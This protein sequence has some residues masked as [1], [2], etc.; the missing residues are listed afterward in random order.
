MARKNRRL[1][2]YLANGPGPPIENVAED[3]SFSIALHIAYNYLLRPSSQACRGIT[4]PIKMTELKELIR[5]YCGLL[6]QETRIEERKAHLKAAIAEQ[7]AQTNLTSTTTEHGSAVRMSR[8]KLRPKPEQV[9]GLLSNE[10]L[11]A[12]A[13]FT[14][15][16]VK[17]LL[18]PKYGRNNLLPLF[19]IEKAEMVLIK[20]PA[21]ERGL[22]QG[23]PER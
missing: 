20:R 5:E 6:N 1:A 16:R 22:D 10:D 18:V 21:G 2:A 11:L 12:F 19:E 7:M 8:F 15:A 4:R 23:M 3:G 14:P 17:E 9:L 13:T